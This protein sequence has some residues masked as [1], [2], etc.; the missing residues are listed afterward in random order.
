MGQKF[1]LDKEEIERFISE[2]DSIR[3]CMGR[4]C[5]EDAIKAFA[6]KAGLPQDEHTW[7]QLKSIYENHKAAH[8][9]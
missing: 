1:E 3:V 8:R 6:E 4:S 7:H 2:I 5:L 9:W